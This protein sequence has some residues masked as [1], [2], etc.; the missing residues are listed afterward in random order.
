MTTSEVYVV[1]TCRIFYAMVDVCKF[2]AVIDHIAVPISITHH[3][4]EIRLLESERQ[5]ELYPSSKKRS[6]RRVLLVGESR[7]DFTCRIIAF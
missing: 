2:I 7:D 3:I 4:I 1:K 6:H 5:S